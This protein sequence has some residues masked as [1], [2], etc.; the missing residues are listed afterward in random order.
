M[1]RCRVLNNFYVLEG[2]DGVGKSS[3]I[4]AIKSLCVGKFNYHFTREPT[5]SCIGTLIREELGR[6][7][8]LFSNKTIEY[9]LFADRE[10]HIY[11]KGGVASLLL[12]TPPCAGHKVICDR[13]LLS[14]VVYQGNPVSL[15][16]SPFPLPEVIFLIDSSIKRI[17]N[18]LEEK[19]KS[20]RIDR[21]EL[22]RDS[23]I[24]IR[25]RYVEVLNRIDFSHLHTKIVVL[26]N[27]VLG[28]IESNARKILKAISN[29]VYL[30]D[31]VSKNKPL[32]GS[33]V[34]F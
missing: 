29:Q 9:L 17:M 11:G 22:D 12:K 24:K 10:E 32:V 28:D 7:S 5:D 15:L 18:R 30:D 26:E 13:Y 6:E 21:V 16:D 25:N 31:L 1:N 4:S 19:R 33:C 14:S 27:N 3:I 20:G 8:P 23:I 2:V 34:D